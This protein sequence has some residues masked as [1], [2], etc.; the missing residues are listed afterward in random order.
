MTDKPS[1]DPVDL[2]A[3]IACYAIVALP[4]V[5]AIIWSQGNV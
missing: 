4:V 2:P 1:S 3:A 5:L